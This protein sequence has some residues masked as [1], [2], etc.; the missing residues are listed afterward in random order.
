MV[1]NEFNWR[2]VVGLAEQE[3]FYFLQPGRP[4]TSVDWE[5][6]I[7]MRRIA[8]FLKVESVEDYLL[9]TAELHVDQ[10]PWAW[11]Q[12]PAPTSGVVEAAALLTRRQEVPSGAIYNTTINSA[13]MVN[14][15]ADTVNGIQ[16]MRKTSPTRSG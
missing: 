3:S 8:R 11:R 10:K 12:Q 9:A 15:G 7:E 14:V 1:T 2:M 16:M 4:M 5:R 13:A 6:P